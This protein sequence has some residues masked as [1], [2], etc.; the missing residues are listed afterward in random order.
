ML[1]LILRYG[2]CLLIFVG[3]MLRLQ[4]LNLWY[5]FSYL[6]VIQVINF[7]LSL[8]VIPYVVHVLGADGFG[9]IAVAQILLFYLSVLVDY[10]FNRTATRDVALYRL[11]HRRLSSIF[12]TVIMARLIIAVIT[13][14]LLMV[15]V[16]LVP[17]FKMHR[18]VYYFG[19]S[20]VLGQALLVN[21]FFQGME[22]MK[23][24]AIS[25]LFSRALF[26]GLVFI[27]I[28]Q[29]D[30][31]Y[32]YLFFMGLGNMVAGLLSI[33]ASRKLYKLTWT[34]PDRKVINQEFKEGWHFTV[35]NLSMTTIQYGGLFILRLF[36]NDLVV[37][38]Y[39]IAEKIYLAMKLML[40]V[41]S[42]AAYP[43][44]CI[45]LNENAEKVRGF[46]K[47][48]YTFFL[49]MIFAGASAIFL[50]AQRVINFF[51]YQPD[52]HT[53]FLL[54][55]LCIALVIVCLNIP[56]ALVLLAGNHK[57]DYLRIFSAG[58]LISLGANFILAKNWQ[59]TG[60]VIATLITEVFITAG[61]YWQLFHIYG[62]KL[63]KEAEGAT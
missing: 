3:V 32:L 12:S 42:Q 55:V 37:G 26:V 4:K 11:D 40:D 39:S 36:T 60:T 47:N 41:F 13:F 38:Y 19:F 53:A 34:K 8:V 58:L 9:V 33:I 25:S 48:S 62:Q 52:P 46:F 1:L 18:L 20:F 54:R 45:L 61:L 63:N 43:R 28:K 51:V 31:V 59:A 57:K 5:N 30:Q 35:S 17:L 24:N 7:I 22:K 14:I 23:F 44:V 6:G 2:S 10:G 50:A 21:W 49:L 27:F 16:E 15:L 56:A 29:K